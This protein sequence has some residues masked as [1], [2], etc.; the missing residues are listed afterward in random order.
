M[1]GRPPGV[2]LFHR[3][4]RLFPPQPERTDVN[5]ASPPQ[6]PD[7]N[8]GSFLQTLLPLIGSLS[9]VGFAILYKNLI[10]FFIAIGIGGLM[11][12]ASAALRI[13][14]KRQI[15][16][17]QASNREKYLA[18]LTDQYEKLEAVAVA[19][20]AAAER[21]H[22]GIDGIWSLVNERRFLWERRPGD[23]DFMELRL[24]LG[25]VPLASKVGLDLGGDPLIEYETE[26][27]EEARR[28]TESYESLRLAP[29]TIAAPRLGSVAVVGA[30]DLSRSLVRSMLCE[31]SA[32]HAPD[33]VRVMA[34]FDPADRGDWSWLKWLPHTRDSVEAHGDDG[35]H[36]VALAIDAEDF[37]VLL[38]QLVKPRI[39]HL[40]RMRESSYG[41]VGDITFQ[42]A[43]VVIDETTSTE[44]SNLDGLDELLRR[45]PDIGVFVIALVP[46]Q[47]AVPSTVGA[48][49]ELAEGGW[50]TYTESGSEG[51]REHSVR[52]DA[53][54]VDICEAIA[55]TMAP[56]RLR[57]REGRAR[58]VDSEG[59]LDLLN[60][61]NVTSL[62][63]T[64][65]WRAKPI[66]ELLRTAV[67]IGEDGSP[68]VLDLKESA[69]D[70]MGPHGLIVGATGSGKSE[71]LRTLVSGLALRHSPEELALVMVDFKGGATFAEL[72]RLPHTA[73]M[74]TN[75]ERD[76]TLVDRMHEA[77]FG[78]LERRQRVLQESGNFDRVRDYQSHRKEN[79]QLELPALPS[80]LVIVDEFGELLANKPDFLDLF[81]SI[82]RTG[83][84]LGVHLLLATQ[85]LD[86]G[87]IKGLESHLRYRICLRTFSPEE[88]Q[89]VLGSRHAFE[90]PPLPGLGY[91]KIDNSL[92][93]F[94]A[95]LST[96]PYREHRS[97]D[98]QDS[99]K[100]VVRAFTVS[101][102]APDLAVLGR[103]GEGGDTSNGSRT[104]DDAFASQLTD[105][106][107]KA[108]GR[109]RTEMQVVI[110]RLES[111]GGERVVR[112]VWL[113][114]LPAAMTLDTVLDTRARPRRPGQPG[115]L[116]VPIG[117]LDRPREQQQLPYTLSFT[118]R[119]GHVAVVGAPRSGKSTILQTLMAGLSLTHDPGDVQVYALDFGGG[120]VHAMSAAPQVGAVYGR[121]EREE[122][123]RLVREMQAIV[124]GRAE[125]FRAHRITGM[126]AYH[127]ARGAG[128]IKGDGYGDVFLVVDNW[129]LL[130]QEFEE[131]QQ[132]IIELAAAGL[133][134]GFHV[135]VSSNR[136]HDIRLNLRDNIGG[137]IELR[138]NDP[139]ESEVDRHAAKTLP[140]DVPGR[141][142]TRTGEHFHAA[143]P[144]V[145]GRADIG[146][147][148]AAM[149][150]L[151]SALKKRWEKSPPAPPI[152]M[153]PTLV[154]PED[155]PDPATD[156][157][158]GIALGLEEFGLE[159]VRVDLLGAD[160]HFLVFGDG[161]CGKTNLLR[162]WL[163]RLFARHEHADVQVGI[164]DYRRQLLDLATDDK[165]VFGYA[166]S[167]DMATQ[168][169]ERLY[170]ELA[171]RL[172]KATASLSAPEEHLAWTGPHAV[173]VIDD[174]DLVAS[175]AGNPLA[176][177]LEL[178]AQ[179]R[180]IGFHVVLA[181]RVGGTTRSSFEP[182]FQRLVELSTPG[183]IMSGDPQE[184]PIL[185]TQKAE[186]Q[187]PG[188]GFLVRNRRSALIQ[189]VVA[190]GGESLETPAADGAD[191]IQ[192]ART[193]R[194]R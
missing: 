157:V 160:P 70:G 65:A 172:P 22:P 7:P 24:G 55:R 9:M 132:E 164:V 107:R 153:L 146:G 17:R 72:N 91:L 11:F 120:G 173:L 81:V 12:I 178:L 34:A 104:A 184:G 155:L 133:H 31:V 16:K 59:L 161:E 145:D 49:I 193:G 15:R 50:V 23:P 84:S 37:E 179:G 114:P 40:E 171:G 112:Q 110:D 176:G 190:A 108:P 188:R 83:R 1:S 93:Q 53:A 19:Q 192:G 88:S 75:L 187:P 156:Q 96:R 80:L 95:A 3:P 33:D 166:Y 121:S 79:P 67:G 61:A 98:H 135:I 144:R 170:G 97:L 27:L 44:V 134:Y 13:Q 175:P 194:T 45:A 86:E 163:Q 183:L 2:V 18:Y 78:E 169:A 5:I 165:H 148:G 32:L 181:R 151:I 147:I 30:P 182:F 6:V 51:R 69:E 64:E 123:S 150:A 26:L 154:H 62:E 82:G 35:R 77:L 54:G 124:S 143:L 119:E 137:R 28:L 90:L 92:Q 94:K 111:F 191:P 43:V 125:Q 136:W 177:L 127:R 122:I 186:A 21:I 73:G 159:A 25:D 46:H 116:E 99:E 87:R 158:A 29:V 68:I 167:P 105:P 189:T 102:R 8:Q 38:Q 149:A 14:Q 174:Y 74:I 41:D 152:K 109:I 20:R 89:L 115:W 106:R 113:P 100:G 162:A 42:Q 4:A 185:G 131:L 139:I 39:E 10:F 103:V 57:L 128:E 140:D 129:G 76:L 47:D 71:L 168:L 138:L 118:G 101:R 52:V 130:V 126:E 60:V 48:R 180:D 66:P 36:S 117:L 56:L 58:Q 63:A 141:G 142:I 85:R